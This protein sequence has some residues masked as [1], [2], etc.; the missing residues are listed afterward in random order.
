MLTHD[1]AILALATSA[2]GYLAT[3]TVLA[4]TAIAAPTPTRRREAR[5]IVALLLNR[6]S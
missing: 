6:K 2:A 5:T 3:V 1:P 4:L